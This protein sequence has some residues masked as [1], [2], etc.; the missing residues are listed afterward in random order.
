MKI[1]VDNI[2]SPNEDLTSSADGT[3]VLKGVSRAPIVLKAMLDGYDFD[4]IVV[5]KVEP[6]MKLAPIQPTRFR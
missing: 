2:E 1:S 6:N 4:P 3:F 5:D